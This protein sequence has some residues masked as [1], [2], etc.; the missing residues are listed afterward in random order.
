M[1]EIL[2]CDRCGKHYDYKFNYGFTP[3]KSYAHSI[4]TMYYDNYNKKYHIIKIVD[5]CE[6]CLNDLDYFLEEKHNSDN[7][8]EKSLLQDV[9]ICHNHD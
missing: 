8:I 9:V 1:A 4:A 3:S 6:D 7:T 2:K 5:L